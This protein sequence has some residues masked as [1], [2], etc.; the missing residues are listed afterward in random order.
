MRTD[1]LTGSVISEVKTEVMI[2]ALHG[3]VTREV[4]VSAGRVI[5]DVKIEVR[6]EVTV[7]TCGRR[8]PACVMV[9]KTCS[10]EVKVN[11]DVSAGSTLVSTGKVTVWAGKVSVETDSCAAMDAVT[12]I[13]LVSVV[14][15]SVIVEAGKK[16]VKVCSTVE[17]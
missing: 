8:V 16:D 11:V 12:V 7:W 2:D 4:A 14:A 5:T 3:S 1:V 17:I 10:V 9:V 6:L 13:S 15:G